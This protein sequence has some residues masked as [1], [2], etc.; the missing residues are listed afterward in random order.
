V[1]DF[2]ECLCLPG[3]PVEY[4]SQMSAGAKRHTKCDVTDSMHCADIQQRYQ[5]IHGLIDQ[6]WHQ[7]VETAR[8]AACVAQQGR[9]GGLC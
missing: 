4:P 8:D 1:G 3:P 6:V 7:L 2:V 9:S 5:S